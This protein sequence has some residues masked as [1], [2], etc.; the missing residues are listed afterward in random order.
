MTEHNEDEFG[1]VITLLGRCKK[2]LAR[3]LELNDEP[4]CIN[5]SVIHNYRLGCKHEDACKEL[6]SALSKELKGE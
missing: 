2:C 4:L 3:E 1:A 6:Y 5:H